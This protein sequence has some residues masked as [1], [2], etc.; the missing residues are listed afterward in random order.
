MR[1]GLTRATHNSGV[2]LPEPMRTSS[3]FFDTGT[4]GN[5]RIQTRPE[6][7]M[8]RVKAR[9]AASICRAVIRSGSSA[10]SPNWPNASVAALVASAVD[11]ALVRLAEFR[12]HRL[13]HDGRLF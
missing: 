13:Q 1:P 8:C 10:L 4:S 3:G 9:R 5:T 12:S 2:P 11:A 6:R 7:F